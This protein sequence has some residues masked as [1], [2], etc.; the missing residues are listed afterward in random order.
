MYKVK[1]KRSGKVPPH[2]HSHS[3]QPLALDAFVPET[4]TINKIQR[5]CEFGPECEE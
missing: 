5:K 4:L 2:S 3:H 1:K